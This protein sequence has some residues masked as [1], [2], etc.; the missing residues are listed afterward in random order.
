MLRHLDRLGLSKYD[1]PEFFLAVDEIP[2]TAS[3]KLRKRD[4]VDW[5]AAGRAVPTEIRFHQFT[6]SSL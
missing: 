4:I 6:T 2:L 5:I 3:G 1:M